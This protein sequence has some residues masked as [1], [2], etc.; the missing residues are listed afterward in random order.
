MMGLNNSRTSGFSETFYNFS[1]LMYILNGKRLLDP[2]LKEI[3]ECAITVLQQK[4][5]K[6]CSKNLNSLLILSDVNH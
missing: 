6:N 5:Y 4:P 3:I 2:T 1:S